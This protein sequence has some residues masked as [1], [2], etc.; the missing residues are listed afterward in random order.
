MSAFCLRPCIQS[1]SS[2]CEA[3]N[4]PTPPQN[5]PPIASNG[6]PYSLR[7]HDVDQ[8]TAVLA[9]VQATECA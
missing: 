1:S 3:L 5:D 2:D 7:V 9:C 6:S 4:R 8:G